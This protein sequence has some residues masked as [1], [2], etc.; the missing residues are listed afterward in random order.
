[1]LRRFALER[2]EIDTCK[3]SK[4]ICHIISDQ[5]L[6]IIIMNTIENASF[7][8]DIGEVNANH[9]GRIG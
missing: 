8:V 1:M 9:M 4:S 3:M 2:K 7:V 5:Y 6:F